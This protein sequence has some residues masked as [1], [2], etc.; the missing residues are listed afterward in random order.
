M[1][2]LLLISLVV[3][4]STVGAAAQNVVRVAPESTVG[5]EIVRLGDI[6][7]I[8][9]ISASRL[10]DI[11]LGYAPVIGAVR[12]LT[13]E[14]ISL[15]VAAAGFGEGEFSLESPPR[16]AIRRAGQDVSKELFRAPVESWLAARFKSENIDATVTKLELP[17]GIQVPPGEVEIR[18]NF[19]GVGNLFQ[20][21][22][23]PLEVRVGGVVVRRLSANVEISATTEVLVAAKPLVKGAAVLPTDLRSERRAISRPP[24]NYLRDMA[25]VRGIVLLRDVAA[26]E[27]LSS[28]AFA[29]RVV[30]KAGDSVRVEATSGK[31]K[32]V[33]AG[34]ARA[35]GRIGDRIAVK[36]LQSGA[37][38]QAVITDE[39]IVSITF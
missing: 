36:N 33:I 10:R 35:S 34:E 26:G 11:S 32:I 23:L 39:G 1:F 7:A 9:G 37:V 17:E 25:K 27:V 18:P 15:S 16:I 21:F 38:L 29:A 13:R 22:T 2:R 30:V 28:D 8:D 24:G 4:S 20:P 14:Q 3:L 12:E 19:S 31:L 6:S 5:G